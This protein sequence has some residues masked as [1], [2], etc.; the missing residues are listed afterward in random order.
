MGFIEPHKSIFESNRIEYLNEKVIRNVDD[1]YYK[2]PEYDSGKI[3]LCFITGLSGSGKSSMAGDMKGEQKIDHA[4]IDDVIFNQYYTDDQLKEMSTLLYSYLTGPGKQYR[5]KD[6]KEILADQK[7]FKMQNT[8]DFVNYAIK[9]ASSHKNEKFIVEGVWLFIYIKPETLKDYAVYIK[10][11]S[12]LISSYRASKRDADTVHH[13]KGIKSAF[14]IMKDMGHHIGAT[15]RND[16]EQKITNWR[17]YYTDNM[18]KEDINESVEIRIQEADS[19]WRLQEDDKSIKVFESSNVLEKDYQHL[20]DLVRAMRTVEGYS[21]YKKAFDEF[22]NYCHINPNGTIIVSID[23]K[24]GKTE[25]TN[26]IKVQYS[27]NTRTV[28]LPEGAKLYHMTAI[29]GLTELK[30][31]FRGKSA[32]GYLYDKPRVYLTIKKSMLKIS[33]DYKA[34]QKVHLYE[35]TDNI[36]TNKVYVDPLISSKLINGAVYV[37]TTKPIKCKELT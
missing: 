21:D 13:A 6:L 37:E 30:P 20:N 27:Y 2:K 28:K 24:S 3:N 15:I 4:E 31:F 26:Y 36:D 25:D 7:K 18:S 1:I 5:I 16:F 35:V 22:C 11:T 33:A 34:N 12:T 19:N 9:Y 10:G 17:K 29:K 8:I 32:K 14:Y 23:I